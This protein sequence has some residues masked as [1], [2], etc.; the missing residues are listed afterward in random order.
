[1]LSLYEGFKI[2]GPNFPKF[3][4]ISKFVRISELCAFPNYATTILFYYFYYIYLFYI[5][6]FIRIF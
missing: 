6:R 4:Q 2:F 5:A 3:S 1:M